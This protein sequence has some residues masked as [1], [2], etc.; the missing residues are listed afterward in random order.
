[1]GIVEEKEKLKACDERAKL[2]D[3][4]IRALKAEE[5]AV[6]GEIAADTGRF[7]ELLAQV[8]LGEADASAVE[9][10]RQEIRGK[11]VRRA[12]IPLAVSGLQKLEKTNHQERVR[13]Q[14]RVWKHQAEEDYERALADVR[15]AGWS[16]EREEDLRSAAHELGKVNEIEAVINESRVAYEQLALGARA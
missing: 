14:K 11:K 8:E 16:R 15:E 1:M 10:M 12:E 2:L 4:T 6:E 5:K 9:A 3:L 7:M 13:A